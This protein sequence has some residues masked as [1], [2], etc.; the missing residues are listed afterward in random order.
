M[1]P[2]GIYLKCIFVLTPRRTG[3]D[4]PRQTGNCRA[5]HCGAQHLGKAP[6]QYDGL[7]ID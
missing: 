2:T 4:L 6:W 5:Q 7:I 3:V 1:L